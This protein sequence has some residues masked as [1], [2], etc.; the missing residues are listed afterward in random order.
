MKFSMALKIPIS[1]K[2]YFFVPTNI[3]NLFSN[4]FLCSIHGIF[5]KD[6]GFN[7]VTNQLFSVS[8]KLFVCI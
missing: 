2:V 6:S 3:K 5:F 1:I 8:K 7:F 4:F